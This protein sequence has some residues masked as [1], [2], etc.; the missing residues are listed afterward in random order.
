MFS[1]I[2][3]TPSDLARDRGTE[4]KPVAAMFDIILFDQFVRRT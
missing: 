1:E 2:A 4:K 3:F